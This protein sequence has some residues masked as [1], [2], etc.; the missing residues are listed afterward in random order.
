MRSGRVEEEKESDVKY[1]R[2]SIQ[3]KTSKEVDREV[4]G[5]I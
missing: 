4:C 1:K 3:R 5:A 2:L